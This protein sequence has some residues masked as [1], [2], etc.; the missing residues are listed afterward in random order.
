MSW[1]DILKRRIGVGMTPYAKKLVD[2][3]ITT[4]PKTI[5]TIL[6]DMYNELE[7]DRKKS[8]TPGK[9]KIPT[10]GELARYLG[11]KYSGVRLSKKT[12]K[13]IKSHAGIMHY[14]REE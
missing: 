13:P 14:Y 2:R 1:E 6:D 10:R 7:R 12:Q 4:T 9:L 5:N 3:I 11:T 8:R